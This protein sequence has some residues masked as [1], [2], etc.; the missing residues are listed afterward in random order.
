M[1][2]D[3]RNISTKTTAQNL[4]TLLNQ[5]YAKKTEIK[6]KTSELD[7]DRKFQTEEQVNSA[8]QAAVVGSL[9]PA[10]SVEFAN[11]P[12]LEAANLN[13]IVNVTNGFTTTE[14]FVEGKGHKYPAGTNVAIIN[15]S[16]SG[17]PEYK[18]DVY[19]GVIDTSGFM[20]KVSG[21][22]D[23]DILLQTG[24]GDAKTSGKNLSDFVEAV[25]G[26]VLSDNNYTTDDKNKLAGISSE[27][28]K[29]TVPETPD[30]TIEVDGQKKTVFTLPEK[31]LTT[32][33]ISD[34]SEADLRVLLGLPAAEE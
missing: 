2:N 25:P 29:V 1:A 19:T 9:R 28:N 21:G 13:K 3:P 24:E 23:G 27:A 7:N 5:Y 10:G 6:T 30:G 14:S 17:D 22:A 18:Y 33:D 34:Y 12:A 31:V 16:D 8:I 15:V 32:D 11:L 4:A 20:S 26:K